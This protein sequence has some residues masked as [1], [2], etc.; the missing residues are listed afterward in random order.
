MEGNYV[1]PN[2]TMNKA[3][4][5]KYSS[6]S[7][8]VTI[9]AVAHTMKSISTYFCNLEPVSVGNDV[10]LG[11]NSIIFPGIKIGDVAVV[12]AGAVVK[13]D[14]PDYAVV[15]GVPAR[16]LYFR[17]E[18]DI[19]DELKAIKWWR[20]SETD[21]F[22]QPELFKAEPTKEGLIKLKEAVEKTVDK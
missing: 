14:V 22:K 16:T 2:C 20:I 11:A 19:I 13:H 7:W 9:G 17:F 12:G 1:N 8:N 4:V 10:W 5:G 18:P 3:T 21:F 15:A 6:V